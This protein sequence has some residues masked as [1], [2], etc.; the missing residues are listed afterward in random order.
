MIEVI[1]IKNHVNNKLRLNDPT[2]LRIT[3]LYRH[4]VILI[5]K[6]SVLLIM[7]ESHDD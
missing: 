5:Q 3:R 6:T 4:F 7:K 2:L 1:F